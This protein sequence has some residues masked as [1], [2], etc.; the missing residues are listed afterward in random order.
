MY[1]LSSF[2]VRVEL[3]RFEGSSGVVEQFM[4]LSPQEYADFAT[5]LAWLRQA[6][7]QVLSEQRIV[8]GCVVWRRFHCSDLQ[9]QAELMRGD[10]FSDDRMAGASAVSWVGQAPAGDRNQFAASAN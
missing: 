10:A 3:S 8:P 2:P 6:Y 9:N 7:E 5:Q 1:S 4:A